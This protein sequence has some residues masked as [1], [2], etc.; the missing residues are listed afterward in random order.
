MSAKAKVSITLPRD[1]LER[2]D[3]EAARGAGST[4]SSVIETWLRRAARTQAARALEADTIRYYESLTA[5]E[6]Q[7]DERIGR[8]SSR[9]SKRRRY[10]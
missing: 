4:R 3:R 7:E 5:E 10:D 1:L 9:A 2:I 8:A 6:I